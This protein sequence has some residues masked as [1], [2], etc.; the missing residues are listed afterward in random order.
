MAPC[1]CLTRMVAGV[2]TRVMR[3][4]LHDRCKIHA[5][6]LVTL[7]KRRVQSQLTGRGG[8]GTCKP[9]LQITRSLCERYKTTMSHVLG[10]RMSA[11]A[12]KASE[13]VELN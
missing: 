11:G 9:D 6:R 2:K 8:A 13:A 10:D 4:Q 12:G 3:I 5:S 1:L 7:L